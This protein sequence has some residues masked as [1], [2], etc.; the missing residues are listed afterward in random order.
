[1]IAYRQSPQIAICGLSYVPVIQVSTGRLRLRVD[2]G[3]L[4]FVG[5]VGGLGEFRVAGVIC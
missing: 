3:T 5:A 1:M 4:V 2:V